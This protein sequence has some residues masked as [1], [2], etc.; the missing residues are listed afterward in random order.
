MHASVP[1]NC[2]TALQR[3]DHAAGHQVGASRHKVVERLDLGAGA[4]RD[5]NEGAVE[6][7]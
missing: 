6:R 2:S 5:D 3:A 7:R 4:M 1:P